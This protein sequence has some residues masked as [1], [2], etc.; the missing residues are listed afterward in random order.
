[1]SKNKLIVDLFIK[2]QQVVDEQDKQEFIIETQAELTEIDDSYFLIFEH[3]EDLEAEGLET[4]G[5]LGQG[6]IEKT[7]F[8]LK[9]Q[10]DLEK[11]TLRRFGASSYAIDFVNSDLSYNYVN[12]THGRLELIYRTNKIVN[13]KNS[14]N[15]FEINLDYD[16]MQGDS[17]LANNNLNIAF[18]RADK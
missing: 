6:N 10:K 1:M 14:K 11:I 7:K 12:T 13:V 5:E 18:V 16:L 9:I 2:S 4:I 3:F 15:D 17:V 8:S